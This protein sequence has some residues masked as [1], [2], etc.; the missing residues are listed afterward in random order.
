MKAIVLEEFGGPEVLRYVDIAA[1]NA[2]PGE[3]VIR[4]H[5]VSVNRTLDCVLRAGKYPAKIQLPH[6][7]GADPAGEV[8]EVGSGVERFKVGDRVAVVSAVPCQT[9][10]HCRN[11]KEAQ[12]AN[13]RRIGVDRW[14]GYAEYT[15]VPQHH[16]FMLP[17][18][19]SFA[20]G[21]VITRH[22][23]MAFQLLAS[24]TNIAPGESVLVMGA[25][26]ALGICCVQVAKI[27]GATVIAAAGTDERVELA[28]SY[29]ADFGINYRTQDLTTEVM[30]LT[31][32][33][34]VAV[35]CENIADPTLWSGAFNSLAIGGRMV[36]AGAHGGGKVTLNVKTLYLRR[37][38]IIGAAGTYP[39]D[40]EK[41]LDAA[42][43]GK[44]RA[45][46]WRS[47]PLREATQA[48]RIVQQNQVNGKII[49][50]PTAG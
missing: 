14:G 32:N 36:T 13:G 40:V 9:C 12:C 48:H 20:E 47:M 37:I 45:I 19:V 2:G 43:T 17:D 11:G 24:K 33:N 30:K 29:G 4:V 42:R 41:S 23:P 7:P 21:T 22:F 49:L 6:V 39:L 26:G 8:T 18:N 38:S 34:G 10:M 5:S 1:P 44:I 27:F 25:A 50:D 46:P 31:D 35:V 16:A 28:K 3:V 15:A